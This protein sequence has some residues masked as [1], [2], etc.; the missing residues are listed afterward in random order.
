MRS[1]DEEFERLK[2]EMEGIEGLEVK[3]EV[4]EIPIDPELLLDSENEEL[5]KIEF[6]TSNRN[7]KGRAIM[8]CLNPLDLFIDKN[9]C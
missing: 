3:K 4:L 5:N 8:H 7:K 9:E 6:I 2:I 1:K